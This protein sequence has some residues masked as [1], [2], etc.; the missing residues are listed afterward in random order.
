MASAATVV[1]QTPTSVTD[2]TVIYDAQADGGSQPGKSVYQYN[3]NWYT[4]VGPGTTISSWPVLDQQTA[5]SD[6]DFLA[7]SFLSRDGSYGDFI[8]T[9][10]GTWDPGLTTV[11]DGGSYQ[12]GAAN[13]P[14]LTFR[15]SNLAIGQAYLVQFLVGDN[16]GLGANRSQTI[17]AGGSTSGLLT[18]GD[19]A[20][21]FA[22]AVIGTFSAD[23]N[24]IDF[25][26]ASSTGN[27]QFNAVFVTAVPE[28][29]TALLGL[30][31]ML[32]LFR[33]R[34]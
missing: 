19:A 26:F 9:A 33:R 25:T 22:T 16:R 14:L 20:T 29:S 28:P 30:F 11:M 34:R 8:A 10:P 12:D 3:H 24:S 13:T 17:T 4:F 2:S 27:T 1:W 5:T 32:A 21:N 15:L 6:N 23:S 31:G 7:G 18:F